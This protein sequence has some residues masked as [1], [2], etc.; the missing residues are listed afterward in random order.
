MR[1]WWGWGPG[2]VSLSWTEIIF[3]LHLQFSSL[4]VIVSEMYKIIK[5]QFIFSKTCE[6]ACQAQTLAAAIMRFEKCEAEQSCH[7]ASPSRGLTWYK[8]AVWR[9]VRSNGA[10]TWWGV[11]TNLSAERF[12]GD[13]LAGLVAIFILCPSTTS[14]IPSEQSQA[15]CTNGHEAQKIM[16]GKFLLN[17]QFYWKRPKGR[18][19]KPLEFHFGFLL[20]QYCGN[21]ATW[22]T[23]MYCVTTQGYP[24][25]VV[26]DLDRRNPSA[27]TRWWAGHS[28]FSHRWDNLYKGPHYRILSI[29]S[30]HLPS[31]RGWPWGCNCFWSN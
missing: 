11:G 23:V 25:E 15:V 27:Q 16:A 31:L 5:F 26:S 13:T 19:I 22:Y 12:Y 24:L 18:W 30:H 3:I 2:L 29:Q 10:L 9:G 28:A 21:G 4:I 20:T 6:V 7:L 1:K 8:Q 17:L 14:Q